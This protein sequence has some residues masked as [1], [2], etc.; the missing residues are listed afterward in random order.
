MG[1]GRRDFLTMFG[2]TLATLSAIPSPAAAVE[3]DLY[4][5]R[6]LGIAFR[7]PRGWH[8]AQLAEMGSIAAGQQLA[9]DDPEI[10]KYWT[11]AKYL[12]LVTMSRLPLASSAEQFV[13]AISVFLDHFA[14]GETNPLALAGDDSRAMPSIL[15]DVKVLRPASA[16][17]VSLCPAAS[18]DI[19]FLFEHEKLATPARVRMHTLVIQQEERF[20]S[21]RMYDAPQQPVDERHFIESIRVL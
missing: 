9:T 18:Y 21:F 17:S 8:F 6:A 3:D 14:V 16:L 5:N 20:Y 7:K 15:R 12:P 10:T 13:S 19:E 1:I 4:I 2:A 11:D